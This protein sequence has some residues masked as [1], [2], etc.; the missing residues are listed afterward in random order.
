MSLLEL[1]LF[2]N[3]FEDLCV[4]MSEYDMVSLRFSSGISLVF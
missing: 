4:K 3:R 1:L 2:I